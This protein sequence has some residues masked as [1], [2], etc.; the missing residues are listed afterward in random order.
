[1]ERETWTRQFCHYVDYVD[2]LLYKRAKSLEEYASTATLKR[3]VDSVISGS[4]AAEFT[5][6][7]I[8]SH[9][10]VILAL[11]RLDTHGEL[12][13]AC[14]AVTL[15]CSEESVQTVCG[16][17]NAVHRLL[18][19]AEAKQRD[20]E[21][22]K[23]CMNAVGMLC[24]QH[25]ENHELFE[26]DRVV[27]IMRENAAKPD[28]QTVCMGVMLD[29]SSLLSDEPGELNASI[30]RRLFEGGA[31]HAA[32]RAMQ[33]FGD[34]AQLQAEACEVICRS[35]EPTVSCGDMLHVS[36]EDC[37]SAVVSAMTRFPE[38]K[39]IQSSG[40][41]CLASMYVACTDPIIMGT[42]VTAIKNHPKDEL[43]IHNSFCALRNI[44]FNGTKGIRKTIINQVT[45]H[46][47]KC[48]K[49]LSI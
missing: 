2:N 9:K 8:I 39:E 18:R 37:I 7:Q 33:A 30:R 44:S 25:E 20:V 35:L 49:K 4:E 3:R 23:T 17:L 12:A 6:E 16:R 5:P 22:V 46:L 1:M 48:C 34:D 11:D 10:S 14:S 19:A 24:F 15:H 32:V 36:T 42:I 43:V 45:N 40:S 28:I 31:H 27:E 26:V 13:E 47:R 21:L 29:A 38:N 41:S